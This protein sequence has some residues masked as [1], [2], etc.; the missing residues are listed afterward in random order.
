MAGGF[1]QALD[2]DAGSVLESSGGEKMVR[3]S[4]RG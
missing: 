4:D 3:I 2:L 1:D